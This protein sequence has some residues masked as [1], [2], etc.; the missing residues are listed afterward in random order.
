MSSLLFSCCAC[1]VVLQR[2]ETH[3]KAQRSVCHGAGLVQTRIGPRCPPRM[4]GIAGVRG[5]RCDPC[6]RQV[7][8]PRSVSRSGAAAGHPDVQRWSAIAYFLSEWRKKKVGR[9]SVSMGPSKGMCVQGMAAATGRTV[10][11]NEVSHLWR[12][13]LG[14]HFTN[15]RCGNSAPM[16]VQ[17]KLLKR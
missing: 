10:E 6:D 5:R 12:C 1:L 16:V 17:H 7:Q 15:S 3:L 11:S 13:C 14:P 9:L 4:I 2:D 8:A